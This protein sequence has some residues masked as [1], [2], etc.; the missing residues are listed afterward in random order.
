MGNLTLE[1][2]RRKEDYSRQR[3]FQLSNWFEYLAPWTNLLSGV[4]L[5][6]Q[7]P[8]NTTLQ[9]GKRKI[10]KLRNSVFV[11]VTIMGKLDFSKVVKS[12]IKQ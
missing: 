6:K 5:A 3:E 9:T 12:H 4:G 10:N 8:F 11:L 1:T 2:E 7:E